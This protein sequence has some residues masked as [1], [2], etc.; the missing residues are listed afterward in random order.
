[1][2]MPEP[3]T[4]D[5]AQALR[6]S[7]FAYLDVLEPIRP[8]LFRYCLK[9][10]GNIWRAE[11][12]AQDALLR[13]FGS[14]GRGDLHAPGSAMASPK[15]WLFRVASNLWIDAMR[16][17]AR[18]ANA[19][20]EP[21]GEAPPPDQAVALAEAAGRLM[22]LTSPQERAALVLKE[23]F[24]FELT[25]I[26]E[27]LETTV[28]AIK[29]ALHRAR[30]RLAAAEENDAPPNVSREL[31]DRF[32]AAFNAHDVPAVTAMLLDTVEIKVHGVGGGRGKGGNWVESTLSDPKERAERRELYGEPIV[33]HI[34]GE[35][36]E[37]RLWTV[38]RLAEDEGAVSEIR[39]YCFCP[40]TLT[41]VAEA[42]GLPHVRGGYHPGAAFVG[43][44]VGSTHLP[45]RA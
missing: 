23:A 25:E 4:D 10:T 21:P 2:P 24:D 18:E 13:G 22:T 3:L 34:Q 17:A 37:R 9:L 43:E 40:D 1:M 20:L 15:A 41:A 32:V 5:F 28:G 36:A 11:D 14:V 38:T 16:R 27:I 42:L 44:M 12:L 33:V 19:V 35:G 39:D 7:W 45:W 31:V 26:A 8:E 30:H 6:R 29:A